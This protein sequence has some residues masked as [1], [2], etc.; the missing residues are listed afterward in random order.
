MVSINEKES[1]DPLLYN[2]LHLLIFSQKMY[3][4][5]LMAVKNEFYLN[6]WQFQIK[7]Y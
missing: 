5:T 4:D 3:I 2:G 7:T 6:N 1:H